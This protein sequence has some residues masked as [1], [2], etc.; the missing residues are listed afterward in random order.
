MRLPTIW[1]RPT[2]SIYMNECWILLLNTSKNLRTWMFD[3]VIRFVQYGS[4]EPNRY[5]NE[6]LAL[7][8]RILALGGREGVY[9]LSI[10]K[11]LP[12][13]LMQGNNSKAN[14]RR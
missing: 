13:C 14:K 6:I 1:E 12:E 3:V 7:G 2:R 11:T 4:I 9:F 10:S 5:K 8:M